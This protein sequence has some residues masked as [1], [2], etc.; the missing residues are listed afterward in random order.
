M[1]EKS[2]AKINIDEDGTV[3]IFCR[4]KKGTDMAE[5]MVKGMIEE[6]KSDISTKPC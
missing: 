6:P 3:S 4:E 2:G 5:A 1:S